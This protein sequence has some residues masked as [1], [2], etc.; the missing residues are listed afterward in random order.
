MLDPN[1]VPYLTDIIDYLP[2]NPEDEK[3]IVS[4]ISNLSEAIILNYQNKQFQFAYFGIHLLYMTY[5]YC[6]VSKV[7]TVCRKRYLYVGAFAKPYSGKIFDIEK[8]KSI[9][10]YSSISEVEIG[11][12]FKSIDIDPDYIKTIKEIVKFRNSM[13]HASG[14][15][16]INTE[17][18]FNDRVNAIFISMS[19]IQT[20]LIPYIQKWYCSII[21]KFSKGEYTNEY[22]DAKDLIEAIIIQEFNISKIELLNCKNMDISKLKENSPGRDESFSSFRKGLNEI[23]IKYDIHN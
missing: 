12:F 4:Y 13:A 11:K 5:I 1:D 9:F 16:E 17:E 19:N 23:C 2:I 20:T 3:D 8:I 18:E 10:D 14:K 21:D 15:F 7:S 22:S 6:T